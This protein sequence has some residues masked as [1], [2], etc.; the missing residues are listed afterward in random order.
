VCH[1]WF[2]Q[3]FADL[4]EDAAWRRSADASPAIQAVLTELVSR[5]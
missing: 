3:L 2:R 4:P 1:Q 5:P